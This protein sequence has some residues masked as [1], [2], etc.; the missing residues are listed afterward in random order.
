MLIHAHLDI[1]VYGPRYTLRS[2][3]SEYTGILLGLL[4][5]SAFRII[6][7][8][9]FEHAANRYNENFN[10]KIILEIISTTVASL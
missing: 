1:P 8:I 3:N 10:S 2:Y 9:T 6:L 5:V 4:E 7:K